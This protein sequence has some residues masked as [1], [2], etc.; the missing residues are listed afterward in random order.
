MAHL[1]YQQGMKNLLIVAIVVS[2]ATAALATKE[3]TVTCMEELMAS[4]HGS[5][6]FRSGPPQHVPDQVFDL[7]GGDEEG[8][9]VA[10][11]KRT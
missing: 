2:Y 6:S 8:A 3:T 7:A 11:G 4:L 9:I 1:C 5:D 10:K